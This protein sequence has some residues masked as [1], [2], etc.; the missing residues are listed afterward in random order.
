M[1]SAPPRARSA[2]ARRA[3]GTSPRGEERREPALAL[4]RVVRDPE[5]LERDRH[6]QAELGVAVR[7]RSLEHRPEVRQV[8]KDDLVVLAALRL[9]MDVAGVG[10][11]EVV[12]GVAGEDRERLVRRDE[13]LDGELEDRHEHPEAAVV[14]PPQEALLEERSDGLDVGVADGLGRVERE[15]AREDA[16]AVEQPA[17]VGGQQVVAPGDRRAERALSLG[18]VATSAGQDGQGALESGEQLVGRQ[19]ARPGRGQFD[20]ERQAVEPAADLAHRRFRFGAEGPFAEQLDGVGRRQ[21]Q[22]G[23]FAFAIDPQRRAR[24]HQQPQVRAGRDEGGQRR[25]GIRAAAARGCR[26]GAASASRR[27]GRRGRAGRRSPGRSSA[28]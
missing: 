27:C 17:L 10:Q 3:G 5:L 18:G 19:E 6:R 16:E 21:R 26:A 20:G 13:S 9:D 14:R 12:R 2:R 7:E 24:R 1:Y 4:G 28:R 8:G 22:D 11:G 23:E 15:P 25:G